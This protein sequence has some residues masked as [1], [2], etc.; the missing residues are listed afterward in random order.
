MPHRM[1]LSTVRSK[2]PEGCTPL[3]A[4][5]TLADPPRQTGG[6]IAV[7]STKLRQKSGDIDSHLAILWSHVQPKRF[8]QQDWGESPLRCQLAAGVPLSVSLEPRSTWHDIDC[9]HCL[10]T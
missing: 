4:R 3:L 5:K 10:S 6:A 1:A 2:Y 7:R 9:R 8:Y